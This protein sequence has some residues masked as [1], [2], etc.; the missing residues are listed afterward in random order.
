MGRNCCSTGNRF[1]NYSECKR[2]GYCGYPAGQFPDAL[3]FPCQGK[4]C[5][6]ASEGNVWYN[7]ETACNR[8]D[9]GSPCGGYDMFEVNTPITKSGIIIDY[10][11]ESRFCCRPTTQDT[12]K[13]SK[14]VE[15]SVEEQK[16]TAKDSKAVEKSVEE[17]K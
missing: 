11:T 4:S 13:D 14:A 3:L 5:C 1:N 15:K 2:K 17:Q 8:G 6:P 12:A 16:A 9:Y 7:W 10:Q